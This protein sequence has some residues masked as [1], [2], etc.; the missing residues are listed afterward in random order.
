M[1]ALIRLFDFTQEGVSASLRW[2][3]ATDVLCALG[4]LL[5]LAS[6]GS[7]VRLALRGRPGGGAWC[8]R[9]ALALLFCGTATLAVSVWLRG[10]EV[11]HFPSQNMPEVLV[12]FSLASML[13]MCVMHFA[14]GLRREGPAW[15][16]LSDS[17]LAGALAMVLGTHV[18]CAT[19]ANGERDLPPAL[20]S[21]WFPP[22]LSSL[23][24]S[25]GSL[26][27]AGILVAL[28][29]SV[30]FWKGVFAG[31]RSRLAQ[32][33]TFAAAFLVP[34]THFVTIPLFALVG[35]V[36]WWLW[37][38]GRL[39]GAE[40]LAGIER[41]FDQVSFR[42]FCVGIPFLTAGLF[43][44]AF[45]AQEAWANYWG[46]DSKENTALVSWLMYV[47]YVHARM[48]GGWRGEKAMA[49]L[50]AGAASIF[51]TF[52]LFGYMPDSQKNSMH[53]YTDAVAPPREGQ[54][55]MSP[56]QEQA[57]AEPRASDGSR[58]SG[59]ERAR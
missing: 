44:G 11:N 34:F 40:R 46:W 25:Y 33:L 23:I 54:Q 9:G 27:I 5:A 57:R 41:K 58:P 16:V 15:Q 49:L 8:Q 38:R 6:A 45:W 59:A 48:I 56:S 10:I 52:Q 37:L 21:Y 29:F 35:A 17:I 28:Y 4:V 30:A 18:Y 24:F 22:H 13:S 26:A 14:L 12:M 32:V 50:G 36:M 55:G 43:M 7:H 39:P 19:L 47:L 1:E 51:V 20:Q 31:G 2:Q 53:K 3:R 42:A